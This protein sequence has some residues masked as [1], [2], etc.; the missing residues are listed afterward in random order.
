MVRVVAALLVLLV[1]CLHAAAKAEPSIQIISETD[2]AYFGDTIVVEIR[3]SGLLDPIDFG[4]LER[5]AE[6][7]RQTAGTR[8]AVVGGEVIDISSLRI[9]LRPRRIGR[10]TL[11]PLRSGD[12]V[13]NSVVAEIIEMRPIP[14]QPGAQDIK[15]EQSVST[16][17]PLLQQQVVLDIILTARHPIAGEQVTLPDLRPFRA[18]TIFAERRTVDKGIANLA[19]RYL[20]FP[21]Q[22]GRVALAGARITGTI[23]KSRLERA[24][25]DLA[26]IATDLDVAPSKFPPTSWWIA[27]SSLT[28]SDAWSSDVKALSAGDEIERTITV[29]AKGVLPEQIP[30]VAMP[31]TNGLTVVALETARRTESNEDGAT[32]IATFRFRVRALSP[33]PVFLDTVRLRW[34]NTVT[35]AAQ[36]AI[37]PARRIDIGIPDRGRLIEHAVG[38]MGWLDTMRAVLAGH[39][40]L[41]W[42]ASAVAAILV[43]LAASRI[44]PGRMIAGIRRRRSVREALRTGDARAL[45]ALVRHA[46]EISR[47][48]AG[49]ATARKMLE[50]NL[51]GQEPVA[52]DRLQIR[53]LVIGFPR[54][55][56]RSA[57]S[58][59]R[60][61]EL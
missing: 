36:D 3:W 46:A 31:E 16:T 19:W 54:G 27:A 58:R 8:L 5:D 10:L 26:A 32:A 24:S 18:V 4:P 22:S 51:F 1:T 55:P 35:N 37:I 56:A 47:K 44:R 13:S 23:T 60:L 34:W 33:I 38:D 7:V 61:P 39:A 20:L 6:I 25:F 17:A 30:Q 21:Q 49:V 40:A 12:I 48:D 45:Y 50:E 57:S 43:A 2:K 28:L 14:W 53:R 59:S 52:I 41:A 42:G 15:L 9:E 29:S 11:G